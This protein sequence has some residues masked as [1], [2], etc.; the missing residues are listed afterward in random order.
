MYFIIHAILISIVVFF[1]SYLIFHSSD[2]QNNKEV[3]AITVLMAGP[4]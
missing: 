1:I 3:V 4:V 2:R